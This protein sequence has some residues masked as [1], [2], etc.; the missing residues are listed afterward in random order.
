MANIATIRPSP[1]ATANPPWLV[2][3][4]RM[5]S[6]KLCA[7]PV[8][9]TIAVWMRMKTKKPSSPRKCRLRALAP[10]EQLRIPRELR[11]DGRRL[12]GRRDD[13]EG[14][15]QEHHGAVGGLL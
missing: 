9:N 8:R 15:Q 12:C 4:P 11:L 2:C 13:Q 10:A 5:M 7:G 3:C 1:M 6:P 14:R